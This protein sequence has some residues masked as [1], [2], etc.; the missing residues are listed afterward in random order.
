MN[1]SDACA[2]C[3]IVFDLN[4]PPL[5]VIVIG[6]HKSNW[7]ICFVS[8]AHE[9]HFFFLFDGQNAFICS[10]VKMANLR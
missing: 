3:W 2:P 9:M 8:F 4:S 10:G 7:A 6:V 5:S 1:L